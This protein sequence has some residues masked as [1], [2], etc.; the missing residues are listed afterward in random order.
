M[1]KGSWMAIPVRPLTN[2]FDPPDLKTRKM[3]MG[4]LL[5]GLDNG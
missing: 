1:E 3:N 2:L 4:M 5:D